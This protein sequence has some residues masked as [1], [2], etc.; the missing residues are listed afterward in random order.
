MFGL[1]EIHVPFPYVFSEDLGS[2]L[3]GWWGFSREMKRKA[4]E[5]LEGV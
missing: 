2:R 4:A 5:D 1:E 3:R